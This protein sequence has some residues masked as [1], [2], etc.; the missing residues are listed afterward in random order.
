MVK[1]RNKLFRCHCKAKKKATR[2]GLYIKPT[3]P[4]Q[5]LDAIY[6]HP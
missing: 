1:R 4:P 6:C 3:D 5:F 2:T